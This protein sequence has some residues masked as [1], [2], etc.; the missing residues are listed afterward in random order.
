LDRTSFTYHVSVRSILGLMPS[1]STLL[2]LLL[3]VV[4]VLNGIGAAGAEVRMQ[5]HAGTA[6]GESTAPAIAKTAGPPCHQGM[7]VPTAA[8]AEQAAVELAGV[9][10]KV[11]APDCCKFGTCTC[12]LMYPVTGVMASAFVHPLLF[13]NAAVYSPHVVEHRPP[14]LPHLI[15]PPIS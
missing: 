13:A 14:T 2:R 8:Q 7:A 1:F 15:R 5:L 10:S 12:A 4:L 3:A 6:G 11:P 9:K